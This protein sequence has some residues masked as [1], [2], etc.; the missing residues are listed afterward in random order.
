MTSIPASAIVNVTPNV[1][2]ADGTGLDLGGLVLTTSIRVPVGTVATFTNAA[3]VAAAFGL[4]SGEAAFAGRYFAGFDGSPVKPAQLNFAQYVG[5][6]VAG[7][8]RG[9]NISAIPLATLQAIAGTITLSINGNVVTS[10]AINLTGA[11]S[12]SAAA[13]LI[14]A[15]INVNDAAFTGSITGNV[16]TVTAVTSG[17]LAVGQTLAGG[18]VLAGTV[19]TTLGTGTG[20]TGTYNLATSQTVASIALTAGATTVAYDTVTGSIFVTAGTPGASSSVSV[21]VDGAAA[22]AL[23]FTAATGAI[24]STGAGATTP[25]DAMTAV[26][27]STQN[28]A[29]FTTL[30]KPSTNDKVAFATWAS[31]KNNRFLYVMPD[32]DVNATQPNNT[33]CAA[34]LINQA[35]LSAT[36]PI[37]CLVYDNSI[38]AFAMGTIASIDFTAAGGRTNLAFR[39]SAGLVATVTSQ[40]IT[41]ALLANGYNFYGSYATA[42]QGFTFFYNGLVTGPFLWADSLIN[43]ISLTNAIQLALMDLLTRVPSIPYNIQGYALIEQALAGP[44]AA[45]VRFGSIRSGVA[46][47]PTQVAQINNAAGKVITDTLT[48]RGWYLQVSPANGNQRAARASPPIN[49]WYTD[50]QSVQKIALNSIEIQ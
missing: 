46:L 37:Y 38:S 8:M 32:D 5:L 16:L 22:T 48:Q 7:Y 18:G 14:Q 33:A 9:G 13:A 2:S 6:G 50:G 45:A 1:V 43:E 20:G 25:G 24:V 12:F 42:A 34:Y 15:A 40:A 28:F 17:A 47:T 36:M 39:S 30:F 21:A 4:S 23:K 19:I 35:K 29:T 31:G 41:D 27:G 10:A 26:A 3:A 49:F 44:I 11:A